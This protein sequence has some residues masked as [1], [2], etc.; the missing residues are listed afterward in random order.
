MGEIFIF[1]TRTVGGSVADHP[2]V[3]LCQKQSEFP[4][5]LY[6]YL[7]R[8]AKLRINKGENVKKAS[9]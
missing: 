3:Y 8:K 2:V 1:E 7:M 4:V 5:V 9:W 6:S